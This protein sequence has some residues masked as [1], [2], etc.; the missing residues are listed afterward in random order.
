MKL[1]LFAIVLFAIASAG[2]VDPAPPP[3]CDNSKPFAGKVFL[4]TGASSGIGAAVAK[5]LSID[6]AT[7]VLAARRVEKLEDLKNEIDQLGGSSSVVKMDVL[8]YASVEHAV[9][10]TVEQHGKLDGAF[11]NAG[12]GGV[13]L[14]HPSAPP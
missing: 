12:G 3:I 2:A 8:D 4:V 14:T 13:P 6:G 1:S 7:V 11:N 10:A 5:Q 9:N